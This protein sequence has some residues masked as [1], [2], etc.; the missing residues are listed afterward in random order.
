MPHA[1]PTD[2]LHPDRRQLPLTMNIG[3]RLHVF[4]RPLVMG[5]LNVTPDSFYADSR[6]VTDEDIERRTSQLI[7][8]GADIIDI[9]ACSTRPGS[10]PPSPEEE[11]LR[12]SRALRIVTKVLE[13]QE[14][15]ISHNQQ[16]AQE[17]MTKSSIQQTVQQPIIQSSNPQALPPVGGSWRGAVGR[18]FISI[19]TFR[20]SIAERCVGEY[21]V[22][23]INDISGGTMD[24]EMFATVARLGVPYVL[25][26][27]QGSPATMQATPHYDHI[28]VEVTR[29]LGERVDALHQMGVC[30][31]IIDPGF[32]FG[33]TIEHNYQL[34]RELAHLKHEIQAPLLVGVSRKSMIYKPLG[35]TPDHSLH[36]TTALNALA[37]ANGAD[38]L[39][40]HD[41][42]P[43]VHTVRLHQLM[44]Q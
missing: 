7:A 5:I 23:I 33:K 4:D 8:D 41:V 14:H 28:T 39:R 18:C 15:A 30:D 35:I 13:R 31:V 20:A 19:D 24:N 43:A 27:I 40:V 12:L 22:H 34:L 29:W 3:G 6:T 44:R 11:W 42:L 38:I 16:T 26:H 32:G 36:G 10:T 1:Y 37:L 9:G 17:A 21:G 2:I 25:T